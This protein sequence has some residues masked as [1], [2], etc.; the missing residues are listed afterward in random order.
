MAAERWAAPRTSG[1]QKA[2]ELKQAKV[3]A[4]DAHAAQHARAEKVKT[5]LKTTFGSTD[6]N[7]PAPWVLAPGGVLRERI[8]LAGTLCA[9]YTL[10]AEPFFVAFDVRPIGDAALVLCS[11]ADAVLALDLV[12]SFVTGYHWLAAD[13]VFKVETRT[14]RCVVKYL[15][16]NFLR[17]FLG[18][19]PLQLALRIVDPA[20]R[21]QQPGP[22]FIRVL[23]L[24]K[25]VLL[26]RVREH[27]GA[28]ESSRATSTP[29]LSAA[30][31]IGGGVWACHALACVWFFVVSEAHRA[32]Q[33]FPEDPQVCSNRVKLLA[34]E[35]GTKYS[36]AL[37][38][39]AQTMTTAGY[40][41]M[42]PVSSAERLFVIAAIVGGVVGLAWAVISV[43]VRVKEAAGQQVVFQGE[44]DRMLAY[45]SRRGISQ[46]LI[47]EA[48]A[49][50]GH[51]WQVSKGY[52]DMEMMRSLP[53]ETQMRLFHSVTLGMAQQVDFLSI[54]KLSDK[55]FWMVML[56][57]MRQE[58]LVP[59]SWVF[60]QG[61]PPDSLLM[62]ASGE[63]LLL[64]ESSGYLFERVSRGGWVGG[65]REFSTR[66]A[67]SSA[68][69]A[70]HVCGYS[71]SG[72]NIRLLARMFPEVVAVMRSAFERR[73]RTQAGGMWRITWIKH[74]FA[75]LAQAAEMRRP[76]PPWPAP[77]GPRAQALLHA[78]AR[79]EGLEVGRVRRGGGGRA[80]GSEED[81]PE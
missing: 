53:V 52:D 19:L 37:Y 71:L 77:R 32:Q 23:E 79:L 33:S 9:V 63:I 57:I 17:D 61:D 50:Y 5:L 25:C 60:R 36:C 55:P 80:D 16:T 69:A 18:A 27:V 58:H 6:S 70:G 12:V 10:F 78:E 31:L 13:G 35:Q 34:A 44:T 15:S 29:L 56:R 51:R 66:G 72:A 75:I 67:T 40:G 11:L 38:W 65:T 42:P 64:H 48:A 2:E 26:L 20:G 30:K 74:R 43:S 68:L 8:R 39:A 54:R 22:S 14:L 21:M 45:M 4:V 41:D 62:V 1:W 47:D 46:H 3:A 49:W 73:Q 59:N 7:K 81:M 28:I 24:G 76:P